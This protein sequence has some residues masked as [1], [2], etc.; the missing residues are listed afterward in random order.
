MKVTVDRAL[1]ERCLEAFETDDWGKKMDAS[2]SLRAALAEV[3]PDK[4]TYEQIYQAIRPLYTSDAICRNAIEIS[5]DEYRAIEAA[6][7]KQPTEPG[8]RPISEAPVAK[9]I[10]AVWRPVNHESKPLHK[11]VVIGTRCFDPDTYKPNGKFFL[12][13]QYY[14]ETMHVTH[15][16]PLPEPPKD[17]T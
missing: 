7:T 16:M 2:K 5:M 4:L 1:L 13:G 11:E 8:W 12:N 9:T 17:Q 10:L 6:I 14:D 3:A 15:F